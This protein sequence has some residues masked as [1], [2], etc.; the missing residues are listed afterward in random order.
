MTTSPYAGQFMLSEAVLIDTASQSPGVHQLTLHL[1][2][3]VHFYTTEA[4]LHQAGAIEM[5]HRPA[6]GGSPQDACCLTFFK[7]FV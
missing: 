6:G 1:H 3:S 2:S 7:G 4:S 5:H